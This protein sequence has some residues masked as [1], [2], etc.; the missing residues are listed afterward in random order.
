MLIK[1]IE[2]FFFLSKTSALCH[3]GCLGVLVVIGTEYILFVL[4][5]NVLNLLFP[6]QIVYDNLYEFVNFCRTPDS[7]LLKF[8]EETPRYI[9]EY[10]YKLSYV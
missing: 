8:L 2:N 10:P 1:Y 6:L 9:F 3:H 5:Q 7:L 4:Y